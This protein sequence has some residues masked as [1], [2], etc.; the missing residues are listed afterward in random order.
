M[1][2]FTDF[3][4]TA[5]IRDL[6][7]KHVCLN[8]KFAWISPAIKDAILGANNPSGTNTFVTE[9]DIADF[10]TADDLPAPLDPN[11]TDA[12]SGANLPSA[13][14]PYATISD[15]AAI[16]DPITVVANYAALPAAATVTGE[17]YWA[18]SSQGT[19]WL[20]GSLGGTYYPL[21]IYYSNGVSW[22]HIETPYQATQLEVNA[23]SNDTKFVTPLTGQVAYAFKPGIAGGQ[24]IIG[25]TGVTDALTLQGTSGNGTLTDKALRV[26]VGNNG[27]TEAVSI[28]NNGNVT[29]QNGTIASPALN[30]TGAETSGFSYSS[31]NN[32]ALK[33]SLAGVQ[34][35]HFGFALASGASSVNGQGNLMLGY[36]A[37]QNITDAFS[38]TIIG[39]TSGEELTTG[40]Q[41]TFIGSR[42]GVK[43]T[44]GGQNTFLGQGAGFY[45]TVGSRHIYIGYHAGINAVPIAGVIANVIIGSQA[46][47][48]VNGS[49]TGYGNVF[50]GDYTAR[51]FTTAYQNTIIGSL[52]CQAITT[53]IGVTAIGYG[54]GN[55]TSVGNYGTYIGY[56]AGAN[57]IT[58]G[59]V[60]NTFIGHNAGA[61]TLGSATG[62]NNSFIGS[63]CGQSF[64]SGGENSG[65]GRNAFSS[66]TSGSNNVAIGSAAGFSNTTGA[67]NVFLGRQTGYTA[68]PANATTTGSQNTFIGVQAGQGSTTQLTGA[69]AIGYRA[70]VT[71]NNTVILG[72]TTNQVGVGVTSVVA[73]AKL[74]VTS[75]TQGFLPPRMTTTQR[76][77]IATVSGDAGLTIFN[78]TTTK[79]EVW[80]GAA[81]QQ[82]W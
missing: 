12:L 48:G 49:T 55:Q 37:G 26:L 54:A 1:K 81:W 23:G 16:P 78:T 56:N 62:T 20:P 66:L 65:I 41:N 32:G 34:M 8:S 7:E 70:L 5:R 39:H 53:A 76:N 19:Q 18:E 30:F 36:L 68:T 73:S 64:T 42:S 74:E 33:L 6:Y 67:D 59:S 45:N 28:K 75:T 13:L 71:A 43:T 77:A 21:G 17:F 58:T 57:C 24:T 60:N 25:G 27:A 14:N 61:G 9:E 50:I 72:A 46:G 38:T 79:L 22:S 31:S 3:E 80:D 47:E 51:L 4:V 15:I 63:N 40:T 2:L 35:G 29:I 52:G 82:A 10:I 11:I 44:T 69:T